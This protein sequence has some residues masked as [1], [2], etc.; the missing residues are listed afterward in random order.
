LQHRYA[1]QAAADASIDAQFVAE[2]T[3][4][5]MPASYAVKADEEINHNM[6]QDNLAKT[7]VSKVSRKK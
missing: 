7:L 3:G 6:S 5:S 4:I 1:D 2:H